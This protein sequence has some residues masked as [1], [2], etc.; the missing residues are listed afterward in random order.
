MTEWITEILHS[1]GYIGIFFMLA[2]A[3]L[4]P[5]VPAEAVIPL[6]GA[7]ADS[8]T[9]LLWIAI[10][11]GL[12][13]AAGELCWFAPGRTMGRERLAHW[14]RRYGH[15]LTMG[16]RELA[17][18]THWFERYGG[19]AVLL[20]Q[21]F[22]GLRNFVC[23]PAGACRQSV[24]LFLLSSGLGSAI[25]LFLLAGAGYLARLG[26]PDLANYIGWFTLALCM[27]AIGIYIVRLTRELRSPER[28]TA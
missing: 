26:W 8:V 23:I 28:R 7:G 12:G 10:A 1:F 14:L 25:W 20:A 2:V 22:P 9:D 13:S 21:P 11:G 3:R 15:W 6:A 27:T 4:V 16:P 19:W 24:P 5:P 17:R 18:S